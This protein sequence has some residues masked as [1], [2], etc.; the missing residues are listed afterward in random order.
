MLNHISGLNLPL[1]IDDS[2][3]CPDFTF[4]SKDYDSQLII[5]QAIRGKALT[6]SNKETLEIAA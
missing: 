3:S 1:V 2:E 4:N 6:I 5:I